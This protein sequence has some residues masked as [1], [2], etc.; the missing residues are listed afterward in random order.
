MIPV[1]RIPTADKSPLPAKPIVPTVR[2]RFRPV[3]SAGL[4]TAKDSHSTG[5]VIINPLAFGSVANGRA[6]GTDEGVVSQPEAGPIGAGVSSLQEPVAPTEMTSSPD[7]AETLSPAAGAKPERRMPI[8][9][10]AQ[11]TSDASSSNILAAEALRTVGYGKPPMATQFKPGNN[12]N[13]RG[14]P[15]GAKNHRTILIDALNEKVVVLQNGRK[16]TM[17]KYAIGA[18]KLAN[19]LT[20]TADPKVFLMVNKVIGSGPVQPAAAASVADLPLIAPDKFN[21]LEWFFQKRLLEENAKA[22]EAS[23]GPL[24]LSNSVESSS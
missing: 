2:S 18:T 15:K 7:K 5:T 16:K 13:P 24:G 9:I 20:E 19:R 10:A 21:M 12:A 8:A 1:P 22:D 14:R 23:V 6:V 11:L 4:P 3:K 17:T